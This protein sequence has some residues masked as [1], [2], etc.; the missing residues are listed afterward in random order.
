MNPTPTPVD[1]AK[2]RTADEAATR[3]ARDPHDP[4]WRMPRDGQLLALGGR[5]G[6]MVA[7]PLVVAAW[8]GHALDKLFGTGIQIAGAAIVLAAAI[9]MYAL[10]RSISR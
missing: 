7:L 4:V 10:W 5:L 2:Q 9:G 6:W 1:P 3:A 8:A